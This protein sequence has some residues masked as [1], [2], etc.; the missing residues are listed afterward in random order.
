MGGR[1]YPASN[2][3]V[4]QRPPQGERIAGVRCGQCY[5]AAN[6]R[7]ANPF[8]CTRLEVT[9]IRP[10]KFLTLAVLSLSAGHLVSA[11]AQADVKLSVVVVDFFLQDEM[12]PGPGR[13]APGWRRCA[14]TDQGDDAV[15]RPPRRAFGPVQP[16]QGRPFV[17]NLSQL[18][19]FERSAF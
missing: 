17:R 4:F 13:K 12:V 15:L 8:L 7:L 16:G 18:S 2:P 1:E 14:A 3:F 11:D 19:K 6:I 10:L 9:M 5:T